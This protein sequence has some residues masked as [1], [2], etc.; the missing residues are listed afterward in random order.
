MTDSAVFFLAS[1]IYVAP[2]MGE[3]Y[4]IVSG[5]I[6]LAIGWY[7]LFKEANNK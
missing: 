3:T 6:C 2:Y 1:A 4:G 5:L 7:L